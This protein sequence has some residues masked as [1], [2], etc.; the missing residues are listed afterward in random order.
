MSDIQAELRLKGMVVLDDIIVQYMGEWMLLKPGDTYIAQHGDDDP[1]VLTV[2]R[3]EVQRRLSG[4]TTGKVFPKERKKRLYDLNEVVRISVIK[5]PNPPVKKEEETPDV[6][7]LR[8][9]DNA[10]DSGQPGEHDGQRDQP[11]PRPNHGR[12]RDAGRV[13]YSS[14]SSQPVQ[15]KRDPK[16]LP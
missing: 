4:L 8:D 13:D 12:P 10:A 9:Q 11:A 5:N 7:G 15:P 16:R 3:V 2:R 6:G 1:E 14:R